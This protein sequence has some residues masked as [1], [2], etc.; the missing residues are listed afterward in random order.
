MKKNLIFC[1]LLIG[2]SARP[3]LSQQSID[4]YVFDSSKNI[5]TMIAASGSGLSSAVDLDFY[6]D[7]SKRSFELWILN[8][9][10]ANSGGSTVIVSNA[11]KSSRTYKYVKDGNAYHFMALASA[12]AFGDSLWATSADIL[13]A[14]HQTGQYTGP[15]LWS[16]DLNIY[17]IIGNPSSSQVNGSHLDMIHQSPYSKGIA[18]EKDLVYW[19][20]DGFEG[21]LKRYDYVQTHQPG[22]SDHSA[23]KVRVYND[24]QF[25]KHPSL[26]SHIVIDDKKKYLY[27]CDPIG[28][29]IFRVDITSGSDAGQGTKVNNELLQEYEVY[30]GLEIKDIVT[31]GLTSPVG[32][33]IYG[34]RLIVTDNGTDE[35]I[36]YNISD[37]FKEVGRIK[38]KYIAKPDPMGLKVGPDG[39]IYFVDK[40]NKRAYMID[41]MNVWPLA[42]EDTKAPIALL[43]YPNPSND[44]VSIQNK[45]ADIIIQTVNITDIYGRSVLQLDI[46]ST[47]ELTKIDISNLASGQYLITL[48]TD[49]GIST[50]KISKYDIQ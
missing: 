24:F 34:D 50:Q 14:N 13:D 6:P 29:R 23:G 11:N 30:S 49:K 19:V 39:K 44:Y 17:G 8:Q 3:L 41:N 4:S 20:L 2:I 32:I 46:N 38:L 26:P 42:V 15:T 28:K 1:T 43:V 45:N 25:T 47:D 12:I 5:F 21:N 10:T 9:G 18:F 22:G 40:T 33:D 35:I 7:Q 48:K 37:N 31:T 16:S 27:G 36:I